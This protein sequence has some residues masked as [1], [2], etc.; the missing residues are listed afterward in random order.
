MDNLLK[1]LKIRRSVRVFQ[2]KRIAKKQL[3]KIVDAARFA[4]TA[5]NLQPWEF[6]VITDPVKLNQLA[7]IA[8]HGKFI[9]QAGACIA[10]F[11]VDTKYFLEDGSAATC[12]ILLAAAALGIGSCWVAGDKKPYCLQVAALLNAPADLKLVSMVALGYPQERNVFKIMPKRELKEMLH[13][14]KF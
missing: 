10:V 7:E 3:E 13:W 1:F 5:R 11:T 2:R 9:A 6:A 14:E 8:D 4:P 12:N